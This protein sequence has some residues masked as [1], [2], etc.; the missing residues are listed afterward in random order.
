MI[1]I[2]EQIQLIRLNK[3]TTPRAPIVGAFPS[4]RKTKTQLRDKRERAETSTGRER[5]L[6]HWRPFATHSRRAFETQLR[7]GKEREIE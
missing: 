4:I 2:V 6:R 5:G 7:D 1:H 3:S